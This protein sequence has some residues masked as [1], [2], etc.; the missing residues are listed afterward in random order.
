MHDRKNSKF[1]EWKLDNNTCNS[2]KL[3]KY[4]TCIRGN[5][6]KTCTRLFKICAGFGPGTPNEPALFADKDSGET[7]CVESSTQ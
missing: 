1:E 7:C 3:F 6:V 5:G 4:F 2:S